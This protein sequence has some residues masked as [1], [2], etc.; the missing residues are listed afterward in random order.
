M[1]LW[2]LHCKTVPSLDGANGECGFPIVAM[3]TDI[4]ESTR[5]AWGEWTG[6]AGSTLLTRYSISG[7]DI[8][9]KESTGTRC[10]DYV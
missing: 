7:C 1:E 8:G 5:V 6:E 10:Y 3:H 2:R 4:R 9:L